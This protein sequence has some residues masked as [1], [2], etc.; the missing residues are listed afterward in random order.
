M[1]HSPSTASPQ[2]RQQ[3]SDL[4]LYTPPALRPVP[5]QNSVDHGPEVYQYSDVPHV[6]HPDKGPVPVTAMHDFE[7]PIRSQLRQSLVCGLP[8][9][10]FWMIAG[11]LGL[12]VVIAAGVGGGVGSYLSRPKNSSHN[13]SVTSSNNTAAAV[14][15]MSIASMH[16]VD[17]EAVSQYR[18]YVQPINTTRIVEASWSA[19]SAQE[20]WLVSAITTDNA[21]IKPHSP[22]TAMAGHAGANASSL[23]V[24]RP[25]Q[26]E[27]PSTL[28][29]KF[30]PPISFRLSIV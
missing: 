9:K 7:D 22:L 6:I 14:V 13:N 21:D 20:Q 1:P 23:L 11:V 25:K 4:E 16:W 26:P 18:V 27:S 10:R 3:Y 5:H 24:R 2:G 19:S 30:I 28:R 12:L 8:R 17:S 15:D 29:Q